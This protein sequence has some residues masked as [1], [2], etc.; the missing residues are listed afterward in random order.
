MKAQNDV[1]HYGWASILL[2]WVVAVLV[3]VMFCLGLWMTNLDYYH[4]WYH[5]APSLHK[6]IGVILILMVLVRIGWHRF[7]PVPEALDSHAVWMSKVAKLVHYLLYLLLL[8]V[9]IS[10]YLISTADGRPVSCFGLF[11]L[12][13]LF[14][15]GEQQAEIAGRV[16]F[17]LANSLLGVAALHMLAALKHHFVD[18]DRTLLRM[19][20]H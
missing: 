1:Q 12:P 9:M 17:V 5:Q 6:S 7:S 16:H 13:A 2:H 18:K 8:I 3:L 15:E 4:S 10:G 11:E 19:L 14:S 20:G